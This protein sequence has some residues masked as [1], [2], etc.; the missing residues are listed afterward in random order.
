M[1]KSIIKSL[2]LLLFIFLSSCL[3]PPPNT[4]PKY[5]KKDEFKQL[6][7]L[8]DAKLLTRS[9]RLDSAELIYRQQIKDYPDNLIPL[10]DLGY[11][12]IVENRLEEARDALNKVLLQ[13]PKFIPARLNLARIYVINNEIQKAINEFDL[14]ENIADS[15]TPAELTEIIG[16]SLPADFFA[17]LSRL[18]S[19]AF[20][21]GGE[22]D[23]AICYSRRAATLRPNSLELN[24][25]ARLLL[26]LDRIEEAISILKS[27]VVD[28]Q[29]ETSKQMIFDYALALVAA[30]NNDNAKIALDRVLESGNLSP[31][32]LAAAKFMRYAVEKNPADSLVLKENFIEKSVNDCKIENFDVD[33]YWPYYAISLVLKSQKELCSTDGNS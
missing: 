33:G 23:E 5:L 21:L 3:L 32:E 6:S 10:N 12:L 18:K 30:E 11:L 24:L 15:N 8:T 9:G 4:N 29:G 13:E 1:Q 25:H 16:N 20:Y 22:L 19:S 14:I 17:E 31:R 27:A 26:S 28:S 7:L 2:Y